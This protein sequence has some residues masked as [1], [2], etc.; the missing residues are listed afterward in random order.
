MHTNSTSDE[1]GDC[2]YRRSWCAWATWFLKH[3][4]SSSSL[5]GS[6]MA[7][8][9]LG[10]T[11]T[12]CWFSKVLCPVGRLLL[13]ILFLSRLQLPIR[14]DF[15]FPWTPHPYVESGN[16]ASFFSMYGDCPKAVL[17]C[18]TSAAYLMCLLVVLVLTSSTHHRHVLLHCH[19]F[20]GRIDELVLTTRS[21]YSDG[22]LN[23]RFPS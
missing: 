7:H 6:A 15:P 9:R 13:E 1:R 12:H 19:T 21:R 18:A 3:S 23:F 22:T 20:V 8:G 5:K 17:Q 4:C 10:G 11:A 16:N 14:N 2:C